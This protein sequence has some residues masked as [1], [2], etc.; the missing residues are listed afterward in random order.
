MVRRSK[1]VRSSIIG[2]CLGVFL[3]T[4][5]S[6][7]SEEPVQAF[8]D[9]LRNQQ[10]FEEALAY[11]EEMRDSPVS[12]VTFREIIEFERAKTMLASLV[13]VRERARR[14]VILDDAQKALDLFI[15]ERASHP[16]SDDATELYAGLLMR[17]SEINVEKS[18]QADL[19]E[20]QK[21]ALREQARQ[22]LVKAEEIFVTVREKL[23]QRLR[24]IDARTNDP[25]LK[26]MLED[27]R[28]RY[29][30]LRLA[31]PQIKLSI[32]E[33]YPADSSE[34][35]QN[36][37]LAETEFTEVR[38]L[39]ANFG[40]TQLIAT[41][42]MCQAMHL[43][44]KHD[45]ALTYLDGVLE[46]PNSPELRDVKRRALTIAFECYQTKDPKPL[47]DMIARGEPVVGVLFPGEDS[48]ADWLKLQLQLAQVYH[49]ASEELKAKEP[50]TAEDRQAITQYD[51]RAEEIVRTMTRSNGPMK[52]E[53][54]QLLA[55][56]GIGR[57]P[58][59][60]STDPVNFI[61]ARD[62]GVA[63][64]ADFDNAR[65]TVETL[66][67]ELAQATDPARQAELRQSVG[68]A[69]QVLRTA[70]LEAMG[71]FERAMGLADAETP[72]EDLAIV[73]RFMAYLYFVE[74][75]YY[76]AGV[77]GENQLRLNPTAA[78]TRS[79]ANI[80]LNAYWALFQ[81]A[82]ADDRAFEMERLSAVG[83]LTIKTF[84]DTDEAIRAANIL[85]FVA[86]SRKDIATARG[87]LEKIPETSPERLRTRLLLGTQIWA[88]YLTQ[89]GAIDASKRAGEIDAEA[90]AAAKTALAPL[91][92]EAAAE[93]RGSVETLVAADMD[94]SMVSATIA[95]VQLELMENRPS[96]ALRLLERPDAGLLDLVKKKVPVVLE[97]ARLSSIYRTALRAYIGSLAEAPDKAAQIQKARA[98]MAA[99]AESVGTTDEG[100]QQ[101]IALYVSL[102]GDLRL[103]LEA[104]PSKEQRRTFGAG[105]VSFLEEVQ[106]TT[107]DANLLVWTAETMASVAESLVA[108]EFTTEA[109]QMFALAD[110]T[111]RQV[112]GG[113]DEQ[114]VRRA[115]VQRASILRAQG[116]YQE[117]LDLY[118]DILAPNPAIVSVQLDA[119][120]T[121]HLWG[122]AT[123]NAERLAASMSGGIP[124]VN[125]TTK[126]EENVIWGW[127]K[128]AN[129]TAR[130]EN[131]RETF[132]QA[133]YQLAYARFEYAVLTSN[134]DQLQRVKRDIT[135]TMNVDA[136]LGGGPWRAKFDA[137]ARALQKQ[138]GE[139]QR[140][141][142]GLE[143]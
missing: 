48:D 119:A 59:Q 73:Q 46:L 141:L 25:E 99:L 102:V 83:D 4:S 143:P 14:E 79:S 96:E 65:V 86:L 142:A 2:S 69:E 35:G 57:V 39:Y 71:W 130:S 49:E 100:K 6:V 52:A 93:L 124:R 3:W 8:L 22:H 32:A 67:A 89:V 91:R 106:K 13:V 28:V 126:R 63:V 15:S 123:R 68:Q 21:L 33:T 78:G 117:A 125:P 85:A 110:E 70:P 43:Q 97:P 81:E 95:L 111:L 98:I 10:Y 118:A 62:R 58:T 47:A 45:E 101:L 37:A 127:G 129:T 61:Q 114:L 56:W 128:L 44:G 140:G 76:H 54:Q 74:K 34:R 51:N 19:A 136:E 66:K 113:N 115:R 26:R 105:V 88:D 29:M 121:Y 72:A 122:R 7:R 60:Q 103:Q 27:Y 11:L 9:E 137:L 77:I 16:L 116:K 24:Q 120:M 42:G 132:L 90:A 80:A 134:N 50:K 87:Y 107:S 53:A 135:G 131:H 112:A 138:L 139:A 75:K 17:R 23:G 12:P 55:S 41:V 1:W 94:S 104:L 82:P 133:R 20:G 64:L 40:G 36:L 31:L 84:P 92:A 5:G 108:D 30:Q 38:R 18:N 109:N